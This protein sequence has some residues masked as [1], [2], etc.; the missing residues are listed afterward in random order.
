[1]LGVDREND[2]VLLCPATA[3]TSL[4]DP[5]IVGAANVSIRRFVP[6]RPATVPTG[7]DDFLRLNEE[8]Q[9]WV[10]GQSID[11]YHASTPFVPEAPLLVTFDACPMVVTFYDVIPLIFPAHYLTG[12]WEEQYERTLAF[13]LQAQRLIAISKSARDDAVNYLGFPRAKIDVVWPVADACFRRL[14]ATEV[15]T[16]LRTLR[17]RVR[18]PERFVVTVSHFH[19]TKNLHA[20]LRAYSLMTPARRVE[21]PLVVCCNLDARETELLNRLI[22]RFDLGDCVVATG[23]VTDDELAALYNAAVLAVHPSRYEGF[24]LPVVEAMTC[25]TPVITTTSSSLPEVAGDAAV[26]VD[27][28]DA[29]SMADSICELGRDQPRREAMIERGLANVRRFDFGQLASGTLASYRRA[30]PLP[31]PLDPVIPAARTGTHHRPRLAMWTPLPPLPTGIADYSAELLR[32]MAERY[33]IEVFVDDGCLPP[34][35]L[36]RHHRVHHFTAFARR[37]RQRPFDLCVYQVGRSSMHLYLRAAMS[38]H[39]GVVVLHDLAM[40]HILYQDAQRSGDVDGFRAEL[41]RTE[42]WAALRQLTAIE[43]LDPP[44]RRRL[45]DDLLDFY[46]MLA[47]AVDVSLAQIVH[48]EAAREELERHCPDARPFVVGMGVTDPYTGNPAVQFREARA[49]EGLRESEFVI[50]TFGVVHPVKR[51]GACIRALPQVVAVRPDTMLVVVGRELEAGVVAELE[52]LAAALGVSANLSFKGHV[53]RGRFD[54]LMIACDVVVN[55]RDPSSLHMSAVLNRA[56]AAGKPTII[57]DLREW[58][59]LPADAF[60]RVPAGPDE[61]GRL[62][63]ELVSLAL[64][65]GRRSSMGRSARL[66]WS[67]NATIDRMASGYSSVIDA[68]LASPRPESLP[69]TTSVA[70]GDAV[71][72]LQ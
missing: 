33:D 21:L 52:V 67:S 46:P 60:V 55:L 30:A 14:A 65:V 72:G 64:D 4:I 40:S 7:P 8:F 22:T 27:P 54:S 36:L 58:R 18:L 56:A 71:A 53:G 69:T 11:L 59:D 39:P 49:S 12:W 51:L 70:H 45:L 37:H 68:V 57:S 26:L 38:A 43:Q 29:V 15:D 63:G 41:A 61:Q 48:V 20:L 6:S 13:L 19:H 2:Y 1:M 34:A 66:H 42:G 31:S 3:D 35:V 24:G 5:S 9:D 17:K 25:G 62:A 47:S 16:A 28:D 32:G 23:R 50:G 44:L 10:A